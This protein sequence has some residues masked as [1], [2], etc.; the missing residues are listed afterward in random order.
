MQKMRVKHLPLA[1]SAT[2]TMTENRG[3]KLLLFA[4]CFAPSF[5]SEE[6]SEHT[7]RAHRTG[8]AVT[9]DK[10]TRSN[11]T[12][13]PEHSQMEHRPHGLRQRQALLCPSAQPLHGAQSKK[14]KDFPFKIHHHFSATC[15]SSEHHMFQ[16][17]HRK[18]LR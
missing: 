9:R 13:T 3:C 16:Q 5:P 7:A 4:A 15:R 17:Q 6:Y 2:Q 18:F 1:N 12:L 14:K 10:S 11:T 8:V